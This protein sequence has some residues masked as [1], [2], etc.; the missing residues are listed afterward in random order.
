VACCWRN[1][2]ER[3]NHCTTFLADVNAKAKVIMKEIFLTADETSN[4]AN[5]PKLNKSEKATWAV[6]LE[7][8][9]TRVFQFIFQNS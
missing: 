9:W 3:I 4:T 7:L 2:E 5:N 8:R 6:Q 1:R